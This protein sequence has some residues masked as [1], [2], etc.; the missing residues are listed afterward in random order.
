MVTKIGKRRERERK[1]QTK[2]GDRFTYNVEPKTETI[3]R[4]APDGTETA[5]D[6]RLAPDGT[7][8]RSAPAGT[9]NDGNE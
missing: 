1:R 3:D 7:I 9:Q 6:D 8:D 4:L 2:T 5:N